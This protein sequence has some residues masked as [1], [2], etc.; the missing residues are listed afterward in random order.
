M[1]TNILLDINHGKRANMTVVLILTNSLDD[2]HVEAVAE[3]IV[4]RGSQFIRLD[5]D[6]IL[7]GEES[8]LFDYASGGILLN[9][10]GQSYN[11]RNV[12][13]V[14]Y[15][16]PFGFNQTYGF[17][18]HITDSIQRDVVEKEVRDVVN[19]IGLLLS[20]KYWLNSPTAI[21][22]ARIKPYQFAVA[23][24]AG[25]VMPKTIITSDPQAAREF[26]K[27]SQ[28][29]FKPIAVPDINYNGDCYAVETTLMTDQ[30]VDSLD[31]ISTQPV[32]LQHLVEKKYEL[33][34]TVV[35]DKLFVARQTPNNKGTDVVD[36]RSIQ[37][38]GSK[39]DTAYNLPT[40]KLSE[41]GGS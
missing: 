17:L 41:L 33:R 38:T 15:R 27:E 39:Y 26:C 20:D 5:V 3:Q 21:A 31:L 13:S 24:R 11:L 4:S 32:I 8:L 34:V 36:W 28:S 35:G 10:D 25:L 37:Y 6:R 19:G 23:L 18:E 9:K 29:V 1:R 16:K 40:K 12:D 14:W 22:R 7:R 2:S 30:L